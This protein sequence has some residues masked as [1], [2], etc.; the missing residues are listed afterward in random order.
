MGSF[1]LKCTLSGVPIGA[2]DP[3]K[4]VLLSYYRYRSSPGGGPWVP[5]SHP[6]DGIY[7]TYGKASRVNDQDPLANLTL[8]YLRGKLKEKPWGENLC[9]DVPVT[10]EQGFLEILDTIFREEGRVELLDWDNPPKATEGIPTWKGIQKILDDSGLVGFTTNQ[11]EPGIIRVRSTEYS[12]VKWDRVVESLTPLYDVVKRVDG[13]RP[14]VQVTNKGW[15]LESHI[16]RESNDRLNHLR[17]ILE[18]NGGHKGYGRKIFKPR[19]V[20]AAMIRA[21]VWDKMVALGGKDF[22]WGSPSGVDTF[23]EMA[24]D[25]A[26]RGVKL[27]QSKE[28]SSTWE[29]E[30]LFRDHGWFLENYEGVERLFLHYIEH[31]KKGTMSWGDLDR[32]ARGLGETMIISSYMRLMGMMW[33][34]ATYVSEGI[35]INLHAERHRIIGETIKKIEADEKEWDDNP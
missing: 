1:K 15:N 30:A 20:S 18:K 8:E 19:K 23:V 32:I 21:E 31:L 6:I 28:F 5:F 13:S 3:V 34:P 22:G 33:S 24:R 26:K 12:N 7:D 25:V 29:M 11:I 4:V 35:P 17:D 9:H 2:N 10:K 27:L 14:W 16:D